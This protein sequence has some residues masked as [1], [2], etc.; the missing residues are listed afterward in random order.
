MRHEGFTPFTLTVNRQRVKGQKCSGL[1][2]RINTEEDIINEKGTKSH[3][4]QENSRKLK[5]KNTN[6]TLLKK[7]KSFKK[8]LP[9]KPSVSPSETKSFAGRNFLKLHF[10]SSKYYHYQI[11]YYLCRIQEAMCAAS[12]DIR[13]QSIL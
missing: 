4:E 10:S 13:T 12:R 9:V 1:S 5:R 6:S 3:G 11:K 7:I 2:V 8:F